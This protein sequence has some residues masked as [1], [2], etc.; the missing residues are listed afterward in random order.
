MGRPRITEFLLNSVD[1]RSKQIM[2][3]QL[4]L[5][6]SQ[7]DLGR[8]EHGDQEG[9]LSSLKIPLLSHLMS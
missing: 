1:I 9:S 3:K 6:M 8:V 5:G 2:E 7:P 4:L